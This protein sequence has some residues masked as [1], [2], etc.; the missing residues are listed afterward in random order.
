MPSNNKNHIT[1]SVKLF[2]YFWYLRKITVILIFFFI[3]AIGG[4]IMVLESISKVISKLQCSLYLNL[5]VLL[6]VSTS[7][8]ADNY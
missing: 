8:Y 1:A 2:S 7:T 5:K 4:H 6:S 3:P